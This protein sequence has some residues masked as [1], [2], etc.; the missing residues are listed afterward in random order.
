MCEFVHALAFSELRVL[1]VSLL[2]VRKEE[3]RVKE[4]RI[5]SLCII[6]LLI[7]TQ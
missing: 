4:I 5:C 7:G 1:P 2:A 3:G 6:L